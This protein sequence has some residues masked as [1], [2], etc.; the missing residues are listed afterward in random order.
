M[1]NVGIIGC[2]DIS[3]VYLNNLTKLFKNVNVAAVCDAV[4]GR[5][6]E[7]AETF[8]VK[9][10][11]EH[12]DELLRD[13]DVDVALNLTPPGAH[14]QVSKSALAAGK[15]IYTEKPLS[16]DLEEG[17]ELSAMAECLSLRLGGAPDTFLGAAQQT[18]RK[19]IDDGFIGNPIAVTAFMTC[20]GHESWHPNPEFHYKRGGGPMFDMGP[21]YISALVNLLGPVKRVSGMSKIS[22]AQRRIGSQPKRGEIIQVEVPT[23]IIGLLEF[24][25]GVQG[26]IMTSFDIWKAELPCIEIYG[27]EGTLSVP[28]PN[29]FSGQVRLYR[30]E[31]ETAEF[32]P[33]PYTHRYSENARGLGLSDMID[34]LENGRPHRAG[35]PFVLHTLEVLAGI[36]I[37]AEAGERYELQSVCERPT[38]M[39]R[40]L[41]SGE[42]Q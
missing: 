29:C 4:P 26:M 3:K 24:K 19:L 36:Q 9:R 27:T 32:M 5:A 10:A 12:V 30:P 6:A 16:V 37:S 39:K 7:A 8:G 22:R 38:P 21:Y 14:F 33:I 41:E 40:Q 31:A 20:P 11:Y 1:K 17:Q 2:G 25:S 13:P 18:C 15:H 35:E 42:V 28:D 34:A 23:H